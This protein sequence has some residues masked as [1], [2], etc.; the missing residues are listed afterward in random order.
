MTGFG[1]IMLPSMMAGFT[2]TITGTANV[3]PLVCA[4]LYHMIASALK[5]QD[6]ARMSE[7]QKLS[8]IVAA[9]DWCMVK[10]GISGTKW[11]LGRYYYDFGNPREP[12]QPC[13]EAT[14]AMLEAGLAELMVLERELERKSG[15]AQVALA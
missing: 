7:A 9:A 11:A 13:S 1:D 4:H 8:Q 6:F 15:A 3:A 5:T 14:S 10:G 2:G 12:L